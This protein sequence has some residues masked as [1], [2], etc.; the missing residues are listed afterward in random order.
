MPWFLCRQTKQNTNISRKIRPTW[1]RQILY[2]I[3]LFPRNTSSQYR[4]RRWSYTIFNLFITHMDGGCDLI[5]SNSYQMVGKL[6]EFLRGV[7][8]F[9][10]FPWCSSLVVVSFKDG[11]SI[12]LGYLCCQLSTGLVVAFSDWCVAR[13]ILHNSYFCVILAWVSLWPM[14]LLP[15]PVR[16]DW[17]W[18]R[19]MVSRLS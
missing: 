8:Q 3:L 13:K 1:H 4:C 10:C 5:P 16:H 18:L 14:T 17:W 2:N 11:D 9:L 12:G 15:S 19:V 7:H 6:F